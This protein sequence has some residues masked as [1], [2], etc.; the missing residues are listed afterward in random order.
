MGK[1]PRHLPRGRLFAVLVAVPLPHYTHSA[2]IIG[3]AVLA[4]VV[5]VVAVVSRRSRRR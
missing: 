2:P 1:M 4:A 3:L 5:I